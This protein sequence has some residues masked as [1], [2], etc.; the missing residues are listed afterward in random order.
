M[1]KLLR[2][3]LLSGMLFIFLPTQVIAD[4]NSVFSRYEQAKLKITY[5]GEVGNLLQQLA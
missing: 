5:Q 2:N 3:V 4:D 1:K